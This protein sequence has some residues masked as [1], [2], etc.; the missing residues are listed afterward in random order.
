MLGIGAACLADERAVLLSG[1]AG[2]VAVAWPSASCPP[3][4]ANQPRRRPHPKSSARPGSGIGSDWLATTSGGGGGVAILPSRG[5]VG[6]I[7]CL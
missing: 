1:L 3:V 2:L 4:R 6:A 5:R 7:L